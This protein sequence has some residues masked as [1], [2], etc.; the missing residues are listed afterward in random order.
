MKKE[1]IMIK[2]SIIVIVDGEVRKVTKCIFTPEQWEEIN[3]LID[4]FENEQW[5]KAFET[6]AERQNGKKGNSN[7]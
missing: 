3:D 5:S 1:L 7:L 4:S 2:N 6:I